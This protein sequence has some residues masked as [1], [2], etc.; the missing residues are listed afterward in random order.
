MGLEEDISVM[1]YKMN[2]EGMDMTDADISFQKDEDG[3]MVGILIG[4][5]QIARLDMEQFKDACK[6]I[7]E[8]W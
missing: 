7:M 8:I 5:D 1:G 2:E 4:V 3:G 6:R